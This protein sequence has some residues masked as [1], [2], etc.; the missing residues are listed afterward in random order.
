MG[1]SSFT[2]A[3][4]QGY[5]GIHKRCSFPDAR[6]L[7]SPAVAHVQETSAETRRV[8]ELL[9][10]LPPEL[11]VDDMV[12]RSVFHRTAEQA[13]GAGGWLGG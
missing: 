11:N 4:R 13:W 6:V 8:A 10:Q 2:A 3:S 5:K 9:S 12:T 1:I 7:Y